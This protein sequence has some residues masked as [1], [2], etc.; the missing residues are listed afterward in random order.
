[1][2]DFTDS[3]F[4]AT[5][6]LAAVTGVLVLITYFYL[7][8]T[9]LIRLAGQLPS[10]AI[11][12]ADWESSGAADLNLVNH[13]QTASNIFARCDWTKSFDLGGSSRTFF[14]MSLAKDGFAGLDVPYP[15]IIEEGLILKIQIE[16]KDAAGNNYH[17][18][19]LNDYAKIKGSSTTMA[20]QNNYNQSVHVALQDIKRSIDELSTRQELHRGLADMIGDSTDSEQGQTKDSNDDSGNVGTA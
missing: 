4:L 3:V 9:K 17:T 7:R 13:G 6:V 2:A 16:C 18:T 20:Y 1:M 5:I 11:E 19:I 14:I 8:E 10:F 15:V 12:P